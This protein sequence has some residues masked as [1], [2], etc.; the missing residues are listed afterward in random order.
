VL[1]V[2]LNTNQSINQSYSKPEPFAASCCLHC[3][4][5]LVYSELSQIRVL[6]TTALGSVQAAKAFHCITKL[7]ANIDGNTN[8]YYTFLMRL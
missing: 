2:P 4:C 1:K 8:F 3:Y 5:F 6:I 7:A